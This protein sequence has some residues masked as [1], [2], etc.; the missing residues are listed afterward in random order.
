MNKKCTIYTFVSMLTLTLLPLG[1]SNN[2]QENEDNDITDE[3]WYV[4][5]EHQKAISHYADALL[6]NS[7][8]LYE[9]AI[10]ELQQAIEFDDEFS[11]AHSLMGSVYRKMG[12]NENAAVAYE[13]AVEFDMWS[14][15]DHL[16][17]GQVYNVL[18]KYSEAIK[19]LKW[20]VMLEPKNAPAHH[21]L[22]VSYYETEN[23][24]AA[25]A[26][27]LK[28]SEIDPEDEIFVAMLGNSYAKSGDHYEAITA[29][30]KALELN[31]NQPAILTQLGN[32]YTK[33]KRF[34]PAHLVFEK[35]LELDPNSA[36]TYLAYGYCTFMEGNYNETIERY[37]QALTLETD[38]AKALNGLGATY[39]MLYLGNKEDVQMGIDALTKWRESLEINPHQ[40]KI[41]SLEKKWTKI[42][43]L[44][45]PV[46]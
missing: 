27:A 21:T 1:C 35:A 36:N 13:R 10:A 38:N 41:K 42:I 18:T 29:Y 31:G 30:K 33:L 37:T 23:Y 9:D 6:M 7:T 24:S 28:A 11:L 14:F 15:I 25:K 3:Y 34:A 5:E 44:P 16:N 43:N 40:L 17:L 45:A 22:S 19:V 26:H 32:V 46:E 4:G 39:M 20:A 8:A 12:E 2:P